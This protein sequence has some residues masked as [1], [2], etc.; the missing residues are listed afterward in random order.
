MKRILGN[1]LEAL[2]D[3][4]R[5]IQL[6]ASKGIYFYERAIENHKLNRSEFAK[7]DLQTAI[8]LGYANIDAEL[9]A[10]YLIN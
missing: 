3:I 5:A 7:T 4:N 2:D 10:I 1:L 8:S 6:D 9:A